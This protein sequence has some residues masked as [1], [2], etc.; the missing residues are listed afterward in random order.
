MPVQIQNDVNP[1]YEPIITISDTGE[2]LTEAQIYDTTLALA[3]RIEF[4][5]T[6]TPEAADRPETYAT[7]REDFFGAIYTSG[8]ARIDASF[9]WRTASAGSPAV[10]GRAGSAKNPGLL[11]VALPGDGANAHT[12]AFYLQSPSGTPFSLTP[13]SSL[14]SRSRSNT[15]P[16]TSH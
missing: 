8:Q 16:L 2:V 4:V 3:N 12:F 11:E 9:P 10:N 5:R 15:T 6:L 7:L 1:V 13:S 14:P